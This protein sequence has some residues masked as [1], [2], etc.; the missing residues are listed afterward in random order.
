MCTTP[1]SISSNSIPSGT[2]ILVPAGAYDAYKKDKNWSR[3]TLV[4]G[5]VAMGNDKGGG[6]FGGSGSGTK[7]DPYLIFNPIQL[8]NIRNFTGYDDVYFKLMSDIDLTE[9]IDDNSPTEGWE[10]IGSVQS[11][12]MGNLDGDG[13]T[14]SGIRIDRKADCVGFFS[15]VKNANISNLK[16]EGSTIKGNSHVGAFIGAADNSVITGVSASFS[17]VDGQKITAGLIGSAQ[18]GCRITNSQ[19]AGAVNVA[20]DYVGGLVS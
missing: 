15:C 6:S 17:N 4:Y 14:I 11:P 5:Y 20:G 19:Y 3:Y 8:H 13:H 16:I 9:F 12:F 1:P 7:D 18:D 2:V 10:P